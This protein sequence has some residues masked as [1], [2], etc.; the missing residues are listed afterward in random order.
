MALGR[1][2][3]HK[4]LEKEISGTRDRVS[5]TSKGTDLSAT[6]KGEFTLC[7]Q[8]SQSFIHPSVFCPLWF[9]LRDGMVCCVHSIHCF[10]LFYWIKTIY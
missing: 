2:K 10:F 9:D 8:L 3:E 1:Q 7:S 4:N 5:K 6:Q